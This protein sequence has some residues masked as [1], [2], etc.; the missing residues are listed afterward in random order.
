MSE[1][2][3]V[4]SLCIA[5]P[6]L[7]GGVSA[8]P[9]AEPYPVFIAAGGASVYSGPGDDYYA[10]QQLP[11]G[12]ECEVYEEL[13]DGWLAIRPPAG[14]FSLVLRSALGPMEGDVSQVVRG[15]TPARVGSVLVDKYSSVHVRLDEGEVVHVID[16]GQ[17]ENTQWATIAP[18]AGE[19]RWVRERDVALSPPEPTTDIVAADVR[20]VEESAPAA[21]DDP[22]SQWRKQADDALANVD[23]E[24]E[25]QI[26]SHDAPEPNKPAA[27]APTEPTSTPG[28]SVSGSFAAELDQLEIE[29]SRRV[30]GPVNL[31]VFDDLEQRAAQLLSGARTPAA[32]K[33]VDD[34][35]SRLNRFGA[36][37]TRYRTAETKADPTLESIA[38]STSPAISP[39]PALAQYDAVGVLR[40]VVSKHGN[41]PPYALVDDTGNVVTFVT[42]S[43][44]LNLQQ[45]L[46]QRVGVSGT[47]GFLPEFRSRNIQTA[48]VAPVDS[49]VL[50]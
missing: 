42:P 28:P 27:T 11:A 12:T 15:G 32:E 13:R 35:A 29:L 8:E 26:V 24:P 21:A 46:G 36:I 16:D 10:T 47:R 7:C 49:P 14:S 37:G 6:L 41:A 50:R 45:H 23:A 48:R 44:S 40:P 30:A 1:L 43:P 5:L 38:P 18:P 2:R 4:L 22:E 39:D 31:W 33:L 34:L 19:F 20:I 17:R 3:Q 9:A 25:I